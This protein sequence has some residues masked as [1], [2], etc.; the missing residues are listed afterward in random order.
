[1]NEHVPLENPLAK[2]GPLTPPGFNISCTSLVPAFG[3]MNSSLGVQQELFHDKSPT[4]PLLLVKW[5]ARTR[6][7]QQE[8][9]QASGYGSSIKFL[10]KESY[11]PISS[12]HPTST[13]VPCPFPT[14]RTILSHSSW[15][16]STEQTQTLL[17]SITHIQPYLLGI[18]SVRFIHHPTLLFSTQVIHLSPN[19]VP[20]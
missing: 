13:P 19:W 6:M 2:V 9:L 15:L 1:M 11:T 16:D 17:S 3:K 20:A 7:R 4:W 8:P 10:K 5:T 12:T 18:F 14:T